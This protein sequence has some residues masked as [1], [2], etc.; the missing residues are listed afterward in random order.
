LLTSAAHRYI[1]RNNIPNKNKGAAHR[2][3]LFETLE[4]FSDNH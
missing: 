4:A 3:S 2:N 1:G